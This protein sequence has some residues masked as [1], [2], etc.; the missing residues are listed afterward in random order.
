M[1]LC[2]SVV[3]GLG[4]L[5]KYTL[6]SGQERWIVY[7]E[8]SN[9]YLLGMDRH[10]WGSIHL[11]SGYVLLGLL[12]LH[13]IL[14]WNAIVCVYNRIFRKKLIYNLLSI[15]FI[16]ICALFII[17]PFLI[18]PDFNKIEQGKGIHAINNNHGTNRERNTTYKKDEFNIGNTSEIKSHS[19]HL[20]DVRG[21]MTLDEISIKY[22]IPTDFIKTSLNIPKSISDKQKLGWLRKKYDIEMSDVAEIIKEYQKENG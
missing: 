16:T 17:V 14:H 9:L 19:N 22:K 13:I 3:A 20:I 4:L 7:G 11:I 18:K 2:M 21:Y 12:A 10:E 1:F 15:V 6:I 5:I 8:N